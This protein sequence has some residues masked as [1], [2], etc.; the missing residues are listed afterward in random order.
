MSCCCTRAWGRTAVASSDRGKAV[1]STVAGVGGT[2]AG[3]GSS[4]RGMA[5]GSTIAG[6]GSNRDRGRKRA[7]H[8]DSSDRVAGCRLSL[9]MLQWKR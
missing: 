3:V 5:V 7:E 6:A 1:G 9:R 8:R 2:V 4:D